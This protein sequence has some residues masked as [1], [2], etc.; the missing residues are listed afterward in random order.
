MN[1]FAITADELVCT[2]GRGSKRGVEF[3]D[4]PEMVWFRFGI[5]WDDCREELGGEADGEQE[6][7]GCDHAGGLACEWGADFV[8]D[9]NVRLRVLHF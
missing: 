6:Q 8:A 7:G 4:R 9:C 3:L 2:T 5:G 1:L